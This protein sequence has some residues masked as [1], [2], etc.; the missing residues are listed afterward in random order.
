MAQKDD[1]ITIIKNRTR[2]SIGSGNLTDIT[3]ADLDKE[4]DAAVRDYSMDEPKIFLE[5]HVPGDLTDV[6]G[7]KFFEMTS[8][9]SDTSSSDDVEIEFPVDQARKNILLRG[10]DLDWTV[11]ERPVVG[12]R[13][14]FVKFFAP[15]TGTPGTWRLRYLSRYQ[16]LSENATLSDLTAR[17]VQMVGLLGASYTAMVLVAKFGKTT[18]PTITADV[19]DYRTR[20]AEWR[21]ISDDLFKEY[22][23]RIDRPS[24]VKRPGQDFGVVDLDLS[25]GRANRFGREYLVHRRRKR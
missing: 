5:D 17:A 19:V 6:A 7:I 3:Q 22:E 2:I 25:Q 13:K 8:W 14:F 4:I 16:A 1:V 9:D 15:P 24:R 21:S 11:V 10:E 12:V 20:S 23:D 18:D